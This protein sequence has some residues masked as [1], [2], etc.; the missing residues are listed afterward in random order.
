MLYQKRRATTQ[1][2]SESDPDHVVEQ[3]EQSDDDNNSPADS[4][5]SLPSNESPSNNTTHQKKP[6]TSI[7]TLPTEI[8]LMIYSY[9]FTSLTE[10]TLSRAATYPLPPLLRANRV[11]R[12]ESLEEWGLH[13]G[14]VIAQHKEVQDRNVVERKGLKQREQLMKILRAGNTIKIE[15]QIAAN[16]GQSIAVLKRVDKLRLLESHQMLAENGGWLAA[17]GSGQYWRDGRV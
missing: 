11:F 5:G 10:N 2:Q 12:N 16:A 6:T 4:N 17:G 13:L 9:V 1:Q 8:R 3:S 7:L 15:A 14:K